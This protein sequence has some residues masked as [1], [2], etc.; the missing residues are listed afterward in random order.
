MDEFVIPDGHPRTVADVVDKFLREGRAHPEIKQ[1]LL[2]VVRP[3]AGP[4]D[5][6]G[7][8]R[9]EFKRGLG[10]AANRLRSG[11]TPRQRQ[12]LA[13]QESAFWTMLQRWASA[14]TSEDAKALFERKRTEKKVQEKAGS[15]VYFIEALGVGLVKIGVTIHRPESRMADLQIGSGHRLKLIHHVPGWDYEEEMALH[16]QFKHLLE[17]GEWYRL[18]PELLDY[19]HSLQEGGK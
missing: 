12:F 17:R 13:Q 7:L 19:I 10:H 3:N 9:E 16:R 15:N 14:W 5:I 6:V 1:W 11:V 18:E 2:D 8:A 4:L